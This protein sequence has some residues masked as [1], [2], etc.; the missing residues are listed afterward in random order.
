MRR[1]RHLWAAFNA[2]PLGMPVPPNWFLV[3]ATLMLGALA[4]PGWYLIGAGLELAYLG[5]LMS[6]QRF[7]N[8]V[9][10]DAGT[11]D[12]GWEALRDERLKALPTA[13][14]KEQERLEA[15]CAG[16]ARR[17]DSLQTSQGQI[18]DLAR[19]CWLHL[20][21][22]ATQAQVGAV[23]RSGERDAAELQRQ[24]VRLVERLEA[25]DLDQRLRTSLEEHWQ[26]VR[27]RR[28]AHQE[29][30]RRLE[31]IEAELER[32]RQQAAL[33]NERTLLADDGESATES[34]DAISAS[35]NEA[36]RWLKEQQALFGEDELLETPP[37]A[38]LF[39]L[40]E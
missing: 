2:R 9:D 26:V 19:L 11:S 32:I 35:L 6:S 33:V 4:G 22:L 12:R 1:L 14:R 17:L 18:D 30:R 40:K 13:L 27:Q 37:D 3:A 36:D 5:G 34:V 20:R 23:V 31:V 7:R 38:R 15:L 25:K 10:A 8:A 24:E 21:L 39:R 16:I 29:A 28:E